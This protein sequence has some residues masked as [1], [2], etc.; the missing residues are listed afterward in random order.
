[1][2]LLEEC[3][4]EPLCRSFLGEQVRLMQAEI[5]DII[6]EL[7]KMPI[8]KPAD[9]NS[10]PSILAVPAEPQDQAPVRGSAYWA[11]RGEH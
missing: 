3:S 6:S 5:S 8:E 7:S 10:N 9:L 11:R 1:M 2:R 4:I